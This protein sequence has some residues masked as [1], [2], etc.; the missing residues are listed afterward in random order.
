[1]TIVPAQSMTSTLAGYAGGHVGCNGRDLRS[2]DQHV[3]FVEVADA[4]IEAEH[5]AAAQQDPSS[6]AV[7]EQALKI[8]LRCRTQAGELP[9]HGRADEPGRAYFQEVASQQF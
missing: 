5:G 2:V 8:G 9:G 3:R 4:R 1:M 7:A 6:P